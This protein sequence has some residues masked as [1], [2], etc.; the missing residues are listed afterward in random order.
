MSEHETVAAVA[1]TARPKKK[2]PLLRKSSLSEKKARTGWLFVLPFVIGLVLIYLPILIDSFC[3]SFLY[4][5]E[6]KNGARIVTNLGLSAYRSALSTEFLKTLLQGF[7]Q[8]I[9]NVPAILV[10]SLFIAVILNQKMVGRA[11]FR[12]IF[13]I[14][15]ILATGLMDS[16]NAAD[17]I[18]GS[19]SIDDGSSTASSG[20]LISMMDVEALFSNMKVGTELVQYVIDLVNRVY[21]IVNYSGVQMLIFLAG[22]QSISPSI[23]EA[24]QIEGATSWETFWKITFPMISPMILVNGIYTIIDSFTRADNVA[25]AYI[26]QNLSSATPEVQAMGNAQSW[27]YFG[28]VILVIA[29]FAGIA[30]LFVFYQKRD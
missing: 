27:M 5:T 21:S 26:T 8:L 10:F 23:Y 7:Q 6:G 1:T 19:T 4:V 29:A 22:L 30:S 25:M 15:V 9:L 20:T 14:P 16:V 2:L 28:M 3:F 18:S 17:T 24:C 11:A 13:F 12:A